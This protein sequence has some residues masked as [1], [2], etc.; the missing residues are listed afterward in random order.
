LA[1][2]VIVSVTNDLVTDQRVKKVC[3]TLGEMG[4]DILLVGRRLRNSPKMDVRPYQ[5]KRMKLLFTQGPFF[6]LEYQIRLFVLLL[7]RKV[8]ILYSND[9]DTLLPNFLVSKIKKPVLIFDSHEYFTGLP[10]LNSHPIKRGIWKRLERFIFPRLKYVFT[11]TDSIADIFE[12]EYGNRP[13]VVRNVA[14]MRG[15]DLVPDRKALGLPET[16]KIIILQGAGINMDKGAEELVE[17][18]Q[19]VP[20][21]MLLLIVGGGDVIEILKQKVHDSKLEEKVVFK[22]R[23]PYD[24]LMAHTVAADL[25]VSLEKDTNINYRYSL[26]NKLFDYIHAGIPVLA[27]GLVEIKKLVEKYDIGDF[28]TG[29]EPRQLAAKLVELFDHPD[30]LKIWGDHAKAARKQLNWETESKIIQKIFRQWQ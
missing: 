28:I 15:L 13:W 19:F 10:E 3:G 30:Q 9:L 18:M 2:K 27:S 17:A 25:G 7:F 21:N 24:A 23:L 29:H 11:V 4:F 16:K 14:E 26:P 12:S 6:Y 22:P 1:K 5:V 20:E 8:D